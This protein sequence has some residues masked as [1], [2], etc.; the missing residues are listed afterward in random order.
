MAER[1]VLEVDPEWLKPVTLRISGNC[2]GEARSHV[3]IRSHEVVIDEPPERRGT[4]QGPAPTELQ[5][6]ALIGVTNVILK[7]LARR[8]GFTIDDLVVD[9]E[10]DLDRRGVWLR[11]E[12]AR[13]WIEI[14]LR[15]SLATNADD[16]RVTIWRDD[17]ARFSPI[18]ATLRAAG[19]PIIEDWSVRRG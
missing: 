14:R 19:T 2:P 8:D 17:L 7:R 10:A 3:K 16:E 9:A 12:V 11:E 15:I 1:G 5:I 6:A 13:P 18:H 4:D